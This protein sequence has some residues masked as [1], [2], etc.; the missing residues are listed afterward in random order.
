[1]SIRKNLIKL[2]SLIEPNLKKLEYPTEINGK[3]LLLYGAGKV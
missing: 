1:M 2:Y 3:K